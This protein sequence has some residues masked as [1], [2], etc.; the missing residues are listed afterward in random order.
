MTTEQVHTCSYYCDR[1]ECLKAQRDELRGRL[2]ATPPT[3]S[4]AV[5]E[6]KV[7]SIVTN[8][9]TDDFGSLVV[10]LP[11]NDWMTGSMVRVTL[12]SLPKRTAQEKRA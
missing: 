5:T 3:D 12:V 11:S 10:M 7:R 8:I 9:F 1:P 2:E 6:G 4:T